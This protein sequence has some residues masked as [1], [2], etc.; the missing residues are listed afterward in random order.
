M[1]SSSF[2]AWSLLYLFPHLL[3]MN[4]CTFLTIFSS[5]KNLCKGKMDKTTVLVIWS[6]RVYISS[7]WSERVCT[8][9]LLLTRMCLSTKRVGWPQLT[10]PA[11]ICLAAYCATYATRKLKFV[12]SCTYKASLTFTE[13]S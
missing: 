6:F 3:H 13:I 7:F 9:S 1:T 8:F 5:H 2:C 10:L 12:T 4:A 11:D